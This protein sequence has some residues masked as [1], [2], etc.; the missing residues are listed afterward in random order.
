MTECDYT[1]LGLTF[2]NKQ[3][4]LDRV[5]YIELATVHKF[6]FS[7]IVLP[8]LGFAWTNSLRYIN[9]DENNT[10]KGSH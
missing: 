4:Y 10:I 9:C 6:K 3:S 5:K 7:Y 2:S 8:K 1:Y